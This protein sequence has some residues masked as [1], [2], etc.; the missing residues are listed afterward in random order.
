MQHPPSAAAPHP[1]AAD[2]ARTPDPTL[3][4]ELEAESI[5]A[6]LEDRAPAYWPGT[7][8][9]AA[10]A[11]LERADVRSSG[12]L[13]WYRIDVG[14]LRRGVVVKIVKPPADPPT[15]RLRLAGKIDPSGGFRREYEG[16]RL[17]DDHFATLDDD[18]VANVPVLDRIEPHG[19]IVFERVAGTHLTD[20]L[21]A[22]HR[23]ARARSSDRL[24]AVAEHAG[25]WLREFHSV[26]VPPAI[27]HRA[28]REEVIEWLAR[29]CDHLGRA[30]RAPDRFRDVAR[31]ARRAAETALPEALPV[32]VAH[33][34]FA[35][36]NVLVQDASRVLV[37]D[38]LAWRHAPVYE[39]LATFTVGN[40]FGRLQLQTYGLAY[41]DE[42]L[43]AMDDALLAGYFGERQP[44]EAFRCYELLVLLDRWAAVLNWGT[45]GPIGRLG[46]AVANRL[47]DREVRRQL[48]H[49]G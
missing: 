13:Y 18:R 27:V 25:V 37:L 19:G 36:R 33:S 41:R 45:R 12:R 47:L 22:H 15:A 20:L 31:E 2:A 14:A 5:R 42:L 49:L 43:V 28:R 21:Q 3:D 10:R 39:D 23:L 16:L 44:T 26:R 40:R 30:F 1:P 11:V 9:E 48:R 46:L 4:R 8:G 34:D 17:I 7:G 24:L 35:K 6:H 29:Y 38:T 32:A